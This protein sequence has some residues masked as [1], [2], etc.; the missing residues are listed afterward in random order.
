MGRDRY[1]GWWGGRR[2]NWL[3]YIGRA[4][5]FGRL[6][7]GLCGWDGHRFKRGRRRHNDLGR[8]LSERS[9]LYGG[10]TCVCGFKAFT[11]GLK[12]RA[13]VNDRLPQVAQFLVVCGRLRIHLGAW[14]DHPCAAKDAELVA[15]LVFPLAIRTFHGAPP[16]FY[17]DGISA[18]LTWKPGEQARSVPIM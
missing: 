10:Q 11:D 15:Q 6:R 5:H 9:F 2:L 14:N 3:F 4:K 16:W 1:G 7:G 18:L 17:A 12:L 8:R 13:D